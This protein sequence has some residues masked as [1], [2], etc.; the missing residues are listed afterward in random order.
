M[1][2]P[3]VSGPA[4]R[5]TVHGVVPEHEPDQPTKL[6]NE[7]GVAVSVTDGVVNSPWQPKPHWIPSGSDVIVT[8][9]VPLLVTVRRI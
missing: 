5:S 1:A 3:T 8:S 9:P 6:V 4:E 2:A 7:S